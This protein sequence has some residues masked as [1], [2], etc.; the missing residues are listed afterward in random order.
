[1]LCIVLRIPSLNGERGRSASVIGRFGI[2]LTLSFC[3]LRGR[4]EGGVG[5]EPN[6]GL[7]FIGER[8]RDNPSPL[9]VEEVDIEEEDE[10][11]PQKPRD[12]EIVEDGT[13]I[14]RCFSTNSFT[15]PIFSIASV[16][17]H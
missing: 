15:G 14:E 10:N 4:S 5:L 13:V 16:V 11:D 2:G 7:E 8:G 3:G 12:E 1:M 17:L 9:D 6:E